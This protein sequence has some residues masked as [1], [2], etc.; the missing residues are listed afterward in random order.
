[1]SG[2]RVLP[3]GGAAEI[4]KNCTAVCQG[5]DI[6]LIDCGLSFPDPDEYGA[7]I[8]IPD[9]AW[10]RENKDRVR[11]IVIT[12]AHEDH[13]G[14]LSYLLPDV[15]VPIYCGM[16]TEAMIRNK[17]QERL[18]N[19]EAQF[20][21]MSYGSV[22]EIGSFTIE[23]VRVTHSIPETAAIIVGTEEGN[24]FFTADYRFDPTPIDN[25]PT[26]IRRLAQLGEEGVALMLSDSTNIDR[27]G[28]A[29]SE[30]EV[31]PSYVRIFDEAPGR[32]LITTFSSQIH[33]M[34]QAI[35]AC[36]EV[37]RKLAVGGWRME[38]T[39]ET[40]RSIGILHIPEGIYVSLDK[41]KEM[42]PEDV[43]ILVTGS[44]GEPRAAL[45]QMSRKEHQRLQVRQ[46]DTIVYSARPIP[47]NEGGIWKV[48]NN[49][50][51]Q[52]ADVLLDYDTPIHTSGHGFREE[53]RL[54]VQ[55]VNPRCIAPV[56]GE[57]RHQIHFRRML[58]EMGYTDNRIPVLENGDMIVL[59]GG[60]LRIEHEAAIAGQ[61]LIDQH[62]NS[63]ITPKAM[64]ER[65]QMA[66][67]G[68]VSCVAAY[69]AKKRALVGVPHLRSRGLA[70]PPALLK[71]ASKHLKELTS[72]LRGSQLES[73][74]CLDDALGHL[75][76]KSFQRAGKLRPA[77]LITL[78]DS[79]SGDAFPAADEI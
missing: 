47:G 57:A 66:Q 48:V 30:S 27:P 1:M 22:Y 64:S 5:D 78:I 24:V 59:E 50:M 33:R 3:L 12:H 13:V 67:D 42:R 54:M 7:D 62:S 28:W 9:F 56:H 75:L 63:E 29:P 35:D 79:D 38:A 11:A 68:L 16:F 14:A 45:S 18:P 19:Y 49:L 43:V 72:T 25:K 61:V 65:R 70:C 4:G 2:V 52:G 26:D 40:C 51:R 76:R 6:I 73:A 8:V 15:P 39:F 71:D 58:L 53:V 17:L 74:E 32:V 31:F 77:F 10:V 36:A 23:P 60:K 20:K 21:R 69:S 37:G 34:Q 41:A 46:G 44:Q 55:L